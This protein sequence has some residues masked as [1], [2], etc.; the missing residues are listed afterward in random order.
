M[1]TSATQALPTT[2]RAVTQREF[3]TDVLRVDEIPVTPE[4]IYAAMQ[5]KAKGKEG[6]YGPEE[7]PVVTWPASSKI[8]TP[9]QGGDGNE[10]DAVTKKGV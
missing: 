9:W 8:L 2:M 5:A 1:S 6:R 10:L 3:G 7:M 4:K